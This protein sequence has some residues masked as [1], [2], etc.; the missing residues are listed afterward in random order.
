MIIRLKDNPNGQLSGQ[1]VSTH[2]KVF[3][4]EA[5]KRFKEINEAYEKLKD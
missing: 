4:T 1:S 3:A 2:S 5:E